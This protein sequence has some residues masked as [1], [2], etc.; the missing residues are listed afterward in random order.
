MCPLPIVTTSPTT[1]FLAVSSK[2]CKYMTDVNNA[3]A[4]YVEYLRSENIKA[5]I[6]IMS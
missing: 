3:T 2:Y 6:F 1:D 5:F 4:I